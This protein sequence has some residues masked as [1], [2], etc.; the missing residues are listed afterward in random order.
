MPLD[1][2]Y[3]GRSW[4]WSQQYSVDWGYQQIKTTPASM[5]ETRNGS[6]ANYQLTTQNA[7]NPASTA[8]VRDW[9]GRCPYDLPALTGYK[10]M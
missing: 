10:Y 7:P 9:H 3:H 6:I 2:V 1:G 8:V 4:S 5:L